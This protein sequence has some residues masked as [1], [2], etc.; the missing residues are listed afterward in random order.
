MVNTLPLKGCPTISPKK[1]IGLSS[2]T[3]VFWNSGSFANT[4]S[5]DQLDP[6]LQ[7]MVSAFRGLF[8]GCSIPSKVAKLMNEGV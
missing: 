8:G 4:R 1:Y 6:A 5:A 7:F 2:L 3:S